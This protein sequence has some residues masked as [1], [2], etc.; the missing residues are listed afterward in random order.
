MYVHG[1]TNCYM[2]IAFI[3]TTLE[4][5]FNS[6]NGIEHA[7]LG[8]VANLVVATNITFQETTNA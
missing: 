8:N 5:V 7:K 6:L 3:L 4:E 1:H 2:A